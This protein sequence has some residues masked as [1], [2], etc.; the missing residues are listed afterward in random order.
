MEKENINIILIN[1]PLFREF[2]ELYDEDS[3]PPIGLG[4]IATHLMNNGV[5]VELIDA[6]HLRIPLVDLI[7]D[8][9]LKRPSFIGVNIFTTNYELVKELINS[10]TFKTHFIIGGLSTKE[11]YKKILEWE[12]SNLIDVVTGD[13][14]WITLDIIRNKIKEESYFERENR[15]VFKIDSGSEYYVKNIENL[16]LNREFFVNEP[17]EH[18]LGFREINIVT[19]RGCI[20]NC[21]F[22]AAAYSLNKDFGIRER[23]IESI[24]FELAEIRALYPEVTSIRVLDDL[25]LKTRRHVT[26]AIEA[27]SPFNFKWRSM[28]HVMTFHNIDFSEIKS[29]KESGCDEVF[30]GVESGSPRVLKSIN[31]TS[32][33]DV[34]FKNLSNVL[35]A[36]ISIKAYFIYGFPNETIEDMEM[37]YDLAKKLSLIAKEFN[38]HFRTSVF[39]YRPYHGTSIYYDLIEKGEDLSSI[40]NIKPNDDLSH[41]VSRIQ[42]NF[43]SKNFSNVALEQIHDYICRTSNINSTDL[44]EALET[45]NRPKKFK[46]L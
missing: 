21:S 46:S 39:Q 41:L 14:E 1:S 7:K 42:F 22:C 11:L 33:V 17:T 8:I 5:D 3:L 32:N 29:L 10:I 35:K 15:R 45:R 12:T 31:K 9:N 4:Y 37:T 34:I 30:I 36:G 24:Q 25:F 19:S 2:N 27:F 38:A 28:A 16:K 20:Y 44:I 18:P 40:E 6:V 26:S 43:H 13:G 23:G